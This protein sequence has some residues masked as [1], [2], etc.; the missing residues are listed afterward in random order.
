MKMKQKNKS[1]FTLSSVFFSTSVWMILLFG[2]TGLFIPVEWIGIQPSEASRHLGI[3]GRQAPEIHLNTWIDGN[4][5]KVEP[6]RLKDFRGKVV[7]LY[8]FQDW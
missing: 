3:L 1:T 8:F 2:M 7:Y 4:G 5:R 6:I